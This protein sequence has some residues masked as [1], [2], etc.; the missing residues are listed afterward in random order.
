MT[1]FYKAYVYL[2]CGNRLLVFEEPDN[3]HIGLQVPGGTIDP[4]ESFLQGAKREFTEETGLD[5]DVAFDHFADQ[6]LSFDDMPF[7]ERPQSTPG[8]PITGRHIRKHFHAT[9]DSIPLEEW[10]HFEMTPSDGGDPI[11]FRLFWLDL[12]DLRAGDPAAFFAGFHAPL[13]LLRPRLTSKAA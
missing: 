3:P 5:L 11:R 2:T 4:G 12:D 10:E 7:E 13:D 9:L 1:V 8:R 6:D